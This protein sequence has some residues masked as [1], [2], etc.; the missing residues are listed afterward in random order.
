MY[1]TNA[2]RSVKLNKLVLYNQRNKK[3]VALF[4]A[5]GCRSLGDLSCETKILRDKGNIPEV[6]KEKTTLS[7]FPS[8]APLHSVLF[9][10]L[11]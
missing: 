5:A 9:S 2:N 7:H 1:V 3:K 10:S 4:S 11:L 6:S 8:P